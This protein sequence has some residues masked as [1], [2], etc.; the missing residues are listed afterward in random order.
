[1]NMNLEIWHS[2]NSQIKST[3]F[4]VLS[5]V[6]VAEETSSCTKIR[7]WKSCDIVPLLLPV[8]LTYVHMKYS[9]L[10]FYV[11]TYTIM[12]DTKCLFAYPL[13]ESKTVIAKWQWSSTSNKRRN[14]FESNFTQLCLWVYKMCSN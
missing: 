9:M 3:S 10:V 5:T 2:K 1:M 13:T 14:A 4:I 7:D 6:K 11:R 12:Q 8:S